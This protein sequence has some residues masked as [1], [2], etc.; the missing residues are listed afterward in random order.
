V[1]G[2]FGR[3]VAIDEGVA[4]GEDM[5]RS[6]HHLLTKVHWVAAVLVRY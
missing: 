2:H 4:R 6:L 3:A 1:T 5:T